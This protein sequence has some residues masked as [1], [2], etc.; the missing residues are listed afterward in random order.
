ML[1]PC[2]SAYDGQDYMLLCFTA[3]VAGTPYE[4]RTPTPSRERGERTAQAPVGH[5]HDES[6]FPISDAGGKLY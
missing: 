6:A 5:S 3:K 2:L 1:S 4:D